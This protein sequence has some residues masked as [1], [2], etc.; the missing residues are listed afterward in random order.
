MFFNSARFIEND[1]GQASLLAHP[2]S[3]P[4][5]LAEHLSGHNPCQLL[6]RRIPLNDPVV[7]VNNE[8]G[9]R[10]SFQDIVDI[11][12][13]FPQGLCFALLTEEGFLLFSF[14]Q[15]SKQHQD[16]EPDHEG[17]QMIDGR[18]LHRQ[19][20]RE[21]KANLIKVNNRTRLQ[22]HDHGPDTPMEIAHEQ[23]REQD[24]ASIQNPCRVD[25]PLKSDGSGI[26]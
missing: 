14:K 23:N 6:A 18:H 3:V 15:E 8:S 12:L 22:E 7:P 21:L 5:P 16:Q 2:E 13:G 11:L 17:A 10:G 26:P 24:Q 20:V 4:H 1:I 9:D 25:H 19:Q